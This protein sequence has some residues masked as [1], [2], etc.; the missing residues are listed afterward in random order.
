MYT[1]DVTVFSHASPS[2]S[3]EVAE[4]CISL[5]SLSSLPDSI[6]NVRATNQDL[7]FK[8][9]TEYSTGDRTADKTIWFMS[10]LTMAVSIN[11]ISRTD[12][13]LKEKYKTHL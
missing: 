10:S 3:I 7:M 5:T 8:T 4:T 1:E 9:V 11:A 12:S 2:G 13:S 6:Q